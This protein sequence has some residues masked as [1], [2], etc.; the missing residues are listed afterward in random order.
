MSLIC[1]QALGHASELQPG[2]ATSPAQTRIGGSE[3]L[4]GAVNSGDQQ[5]ASTRASRI[6]CSGQSY[7]SDRVDPCVCVCVCV[8]VCARVCASHAHKTSH[9]PLRFLW[10]SM[11]YGNLLPHERTSAVQH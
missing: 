4:L 5:S 11:L 1:R 6:M 7:V 3:Q 8:C 10:P 9:L 2:V